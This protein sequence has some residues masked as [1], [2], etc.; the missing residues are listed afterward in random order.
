MLLLCR[1]T[2]DESVLDHILDHHILWFEISVSNTTLVDVSR[3]TQ[4]LSE[5][6]GNLEIIININIICLQTR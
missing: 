4:N 3:A 1:D 6:V 5:N 2:I